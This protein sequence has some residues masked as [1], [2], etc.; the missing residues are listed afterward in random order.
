MAS[1]KSSLLAEHGFRHGFSLRTGGV[2][3]GPYASLNLGRNVGDDPLAVEANQRRFAAELGYTASDLCELNQVHGGVV[4][5]PHERGLDGDAIVSVREPLGI[6]VADCAA[7]LI[8]DPV[9]GAVAAAHAGWRGVVARVVPNAIAALGEPSRLV[10]AVF[11]CI[12]L[13]AFE[14]G[15][16]VAQQ[17]AQVAGED[18]VRRGPGRPHVD[19]Q[20]AV[21]AQLI[22]SGLAVARVERVFGCT[23]SEPARF[24][25]YRRD[26][27]VTGR[28][29]AVILPRC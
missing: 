27:G 1:I 26:A 13:D 29:L 9:S 25:S 19:L 5:A 15:D 22:A 10:A 23:V 2:S 4:R 18:V 11:P 12:G 21:Y 7:V 6:R 17:L 28:H 3:V 16:E 14:V 20:R 24:F 8:A